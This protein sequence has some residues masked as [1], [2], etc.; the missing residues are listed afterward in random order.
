M[1]TPKNINL[2]QKKIIFFSKTLLKRENKQT[3]GTI[4]V[5]MCNAT[6][7]KE[8]YIKKRMAKYLLKKGDHLNEKKQKKNKLKVG[9]YSR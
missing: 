6:H 3:E 7:I 4:L 1:K 9:F 2:K 5:L 8:T